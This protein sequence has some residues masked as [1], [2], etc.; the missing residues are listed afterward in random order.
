MYYLGKRTTQI[1]PGEQ[2]L[3]PKWPRKAQYTGPCGSHQILIWAIRA[4]EPCSWAMFEV[5]SSAPRSHLGAFERFFAKK[6]PLGVFSRAYPEL[7]SYPF[8]LK[9]KMLS[10]AIWGYPSEYFRHLLFFSRKTPFLKQGAY[11]RTARWLCNLGHGDFPP[12]FN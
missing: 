11:A 4:S 10:H 5:P 2:E 1:G 12:V 6:S 7:S 8:W 3:Q 9:L